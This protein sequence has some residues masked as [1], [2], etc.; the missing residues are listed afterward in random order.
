MPQHGEA[1]QRHMGFLRDKGGLSSKRSRIEDDIEGGKPAG[2]FAGAAI[3]SVQEPG[4]GYV[5]N[6]TWSRVH[7]PGGPRAGASRLMPQ[8]GETTW[9]HM[10]FLRDKGRLSSKRN[11]IEEDIEGGKPVGMFAG[12]AIDSVQEPGLGYVLNVTWSR[13]HKPGG[14]RAGPPGLCRNMGKPRGGTWGS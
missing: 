4:L 11:R 5:L 1:M 14:P 8:H 12:D 10:G 3:N 6:V 7:K 2:M 13:V 9:R